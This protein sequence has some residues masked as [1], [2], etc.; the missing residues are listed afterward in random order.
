MPPL[1]DWDLDEFIF[2]QEQIQELPEPNVPYQDTLG[3]EY[4][5]ARTG[6]KPM[7]SNFHDQLAE[8]AGLGVNEEDELEQLVRDWRKLEHGR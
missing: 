3:D 2:E 8:A 4:R 5:E 7:R 6:F 1:T